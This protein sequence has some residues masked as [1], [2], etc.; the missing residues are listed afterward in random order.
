MSSD[1]STLPDDFGRWLAKWLA[2]FLAAELAGT[3]GSADNY[4]GAKCAEYVKPLG[5]NVL[6]RAGDFFAQLEHR[7][8]IESPELALAIG[9]STPR[10]IPANLTNSLKQR[11]KAMR[12]PL[13]WDQTV[14]A[15][16]RTVWLDRDGIAERMSK[17]IRDEQ[18]RRFGPARKSGA[19]SA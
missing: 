15:T 1:G 19:A 10:N 3:A 18:H 14:S 6:N 8:R 7:G 9:T 16:G 11:A 12:L 17:A 13:P 2:P 5:Q 4:D